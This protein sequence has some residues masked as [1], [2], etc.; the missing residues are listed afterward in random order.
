MKVAFLCL[1]HDNFKYSEILKKFCE[2]DGDSF[3]LH[4]DSNSLFDPS[5]FESNNSFVIGKMKE[6]LQNRVPFQS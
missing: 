6:Y 1:A 4:V 3:F 2:S 5:K